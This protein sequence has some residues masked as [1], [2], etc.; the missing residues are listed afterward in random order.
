[1]DNKGKSIIF[2]IFAALVG[3]I[4]GLFGGGGGMLCVPV[5][6]KLLSLNDKSS[7]A[8]AVMVMSI[9]SIPTLI[10][11]LL[12]LPFNFDAAPWVTV[13][14][15]M[16]GIAGS[17]VLKKMNNRLLNFLFVLVLIASG[18]KCFF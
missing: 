1:M 17:F 18:L 4:N 5:F 11:Y 16:G 10:I 6:K 12:S 9:I 15:L 7:H 8:T 3:I 14:A 13:G 2:F